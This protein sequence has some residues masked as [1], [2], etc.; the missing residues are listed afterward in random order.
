MTNENLVNELKELREMVNQSSD[1]T[2]K[3]L[4]NI[5]TNLLIGSLISLI[6]A[7][8]ISFQ[9]KILIYWIPASFLL[10]ILWAI[11]GLFSTTKGINSENVEKIIDY[12]QTIDKNKSGF[13]FIWFF[14]NM[15]P[16]MKAVSLIYAV[17]FFAL[18]LVQNKTLNIDQQVSILIPA[19]S[20][21]L[22]IPSPFFLDNLTS[23][24]ERG[25]T[26]TLNS[27][28]SLRENL[29]PKRKNIILGA[30]K[31]VFILI[32]IPLIVIFPIWSLIIT[33]SIVSD[34]IFLLIILFLQLAVIIFF[35]SYYSSLSAKRELTNAITNFSD[36]NYQINDLILSKDI[37]EDIVEKLKTLY[38]TAKQYDI[39][40]DD[41]LKFVNYYYLLMHRVYLKKQ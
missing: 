9:L 1:H 29:P 34:L 27:F 14:K 31:L 7:I 20:A 2:Q 18:L 17:T 28:I 26:E 24:F 22:L 4:Q 39:L 36:I 11:Y 12:T 10:M 35:A 21:L 25:F 19:F 16:F 15:L 23:F 5:D 41:S 32:Y 13:G 30:I 8:G 6:F 3:Q 37:K 38:L 40:V 33:Y